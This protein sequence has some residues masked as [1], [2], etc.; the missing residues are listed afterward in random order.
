MPRLQFFMA[1][2]LNNK[3]SQEVVRVFDE[4]EAKIGY[5]TFKKLFGCLLTDRGSEF[6]KVNKY[7]IAKK[8]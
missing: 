1:Y 7:A 3:T 6:L 4:I 5:S 8:N 2:K